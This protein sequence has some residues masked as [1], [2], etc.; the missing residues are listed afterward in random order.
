MAKELPGLK[1]LRNTR[2]N[3]K[4]IREMVQAVNLMTMVV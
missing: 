4:M 2:E 3:G 1:A